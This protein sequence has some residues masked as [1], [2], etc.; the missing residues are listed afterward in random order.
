MQIGTR[1]RRRQREQ[2]EDIHVSAC[3]ASTIGSVRLH[4]TTRALHAH[5]YGNDQRPQSRISLAYDGMQF[6][7]IPSRPGGQV[8][9]REF[10]SIKELECKRMSIKLVMCWFPCFLFGGPCFFLTP[11][12]ARTGINHAIASK[13]PCSHSEH[14]LMS[15]K[16][17]YITT[18]SSIVPH[19]KFPSWHFARFLS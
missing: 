16:M 15:S 19:Q 18:T 6:C 1:A 9:L 13:T 4:F 11:C 8:V 17:S 3:H 5:L 10:E 14:S 7:G 2:P 12:Y